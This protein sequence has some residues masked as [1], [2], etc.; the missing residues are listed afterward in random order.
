MVVLKDF[1]R[2]STVWW[3]RRSK[4][5][6]KHGISTSIS[7]WQQSGS[8]STSHPSSPRSSCSTLEMLCYLWIL[9]CSKESAT[10]AMTCTRLHFSNNIKRLLWYTDT[11]RKQRENRRNTPTE[12]ARKTTFNRRSCLLEE[13]QKDT[14]TGHQV[15][16][17]A[18][19]RM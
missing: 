18:D 12:T 8:M 19:I 16:R 14:Q 5:T 13:S 4:K 6:F 11:W 10:S 1:I 2:R 7:L 15:E 3:W 9:S 17:L